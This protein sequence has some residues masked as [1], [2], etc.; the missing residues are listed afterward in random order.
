MCVTCH[1]IQPHSSHWPV[2]ILCFKTHK[3]QQILTPISNLIFNRTE[4]Y[5]LLFISYNDPPYGPLWQ[6]FPP[7]R[8]H[9]IKVLAHTWQLLLLLKNSS[10]GTSPTSTKSILTGYQN[11]HIPTAKRSVSPWPDLGEG[12]W[13]LSKSCTSFSSLQGPQRVRF[14]YILYTP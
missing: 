5:V 12:S 8:M 13:L 11:T 4:I 3:K 14:V 2:P 7:H 6:L 9:F 1:L 10:K